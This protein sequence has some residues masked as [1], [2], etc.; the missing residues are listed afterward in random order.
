MRK[1]NPQCRVRPLAFP[2]R[3]PVTEG[4]GHPLELLLRAGGL[5]RERPKSR[6]PTHA[7]ALPFVSKG[8]SAGRSKV[9][10]PKYRLMFAPRGFTV[11][12]T[13]LPCSGKSTLSSELERELLAR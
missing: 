8:F 3:A 2:V 12:L 11:W 13:G 5:A 4:S 10:P 1:P 7:M 6:Y 9:R